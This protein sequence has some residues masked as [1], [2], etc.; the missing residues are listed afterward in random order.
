[1]TEEYAGTLV[2]TVKSMAAK[3]GKLL[4]IPY[5]YDGIGLPGFESSNRNVCGVTDDGTLVPLK[6]GVAVITI[7]AAGNQKTVFAV[8][9]TV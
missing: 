5:S 4:K 8:T 2:C 3:V 6:A 1:M 9:V 7:S